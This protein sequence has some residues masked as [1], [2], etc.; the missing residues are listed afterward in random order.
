MVVRK[1]Y[2]GD[3]NNSEVKSIR[4][5]ADGK[6][7]LPW[8]GLVILEPWSLTF[9]AERGQRGVTLEDSGVSLMETRQG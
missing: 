8:S 9:L 4:K 3:S 6:P 2:V 5:V 7:K 1:S